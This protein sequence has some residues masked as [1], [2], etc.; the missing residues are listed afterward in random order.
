MQW[1][2]DELW[3]LYCLSSV[4]ARNVIRQATN[5][6]CQ[7]EM[8]CCW[9]GWLIV[10]LRIWPCDILN[11]NIWSSWTTACNGQSDRSWISFS[12]SYDWTV[13]KW[14][15]VH[16]PYIARTGWACAQTSDGHENINTEY[17]QQM[18]A[19]LPA[20]TEH[21]GNLSDMLKVNVITDDCTTEIRLL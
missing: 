16:C 14:D 11:I 8:L 13:T 15:K 17:N 5:F 6:W 4:F 3:K 19:K 18:N 12:M 1:K 9:K 7:H 2:T 20:I 10:F 21:S